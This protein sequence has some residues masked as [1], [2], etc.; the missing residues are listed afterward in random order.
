MICSPWTGLGTS[1]QR[2]KFSLRKGHELLLEPTFLLVAL[3]RIPHCVQA[4]MQL[5]LRQRDHE[6]M[7]E[8]QH[9][10]PCVGDAT[11]W[12]GGNAFTARALRLQVQVGTCDATKGPLQCQR[13]QRFEHTQR[14]CCYAPKG[15]ACGY[16]HTSGNCVTPKQQ[17]KC[18]SC[19]GNDTGIYRGCRKWKRAKAAAAKQT[20]VETGGK[21]EVATRLPVPI[22]APSILSP[23]HER[24]DLGWKHV[25]QGDRVIETQATPTQTPNS[26]LDK[27][28]SQ[29]KAAGPETWPP[30]TKY[31]HAVPC[32]LPR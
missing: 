11:S 26:D 6:A 20:Q 17:L 18:C 19:V 5:R 8:R 16:A 1:K 24:L 14:N 12:T 13:C 32:I 28:T 31:A 25:V 7:N 4:I 3:R 15:V 21:D 22:A 23:E 29:W 9:H 2:K 27:W 30:V 10:T